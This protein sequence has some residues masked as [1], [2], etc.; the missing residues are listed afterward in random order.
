MENYILVNISYTNELH[1][2]IDSN[3]DK[4]NDCYFEQVESLQENIIEKAIIKHIIYQPDIIYN[5]SDGMA[6]R[7]WFAT[8]IDNG[9]IN[10]YFRNFSHLVKMYEEKGYKFV[11]ST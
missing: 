5:E 2:G 9:I 4:L 10:Y 3:Y 1:L 6:G 8:I 7:C 11:K